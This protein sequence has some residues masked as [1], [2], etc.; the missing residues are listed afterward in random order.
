M[1]QNASSHVS[2]RYFIKA[3]SKVT[4]LN[5]II[6]E[7]T[8]T[9]WCLWYHQESSCTCWQSHGSN[10]KQLLQEAR[11]RQPLGLSLSTLK[12]VLNVGIN[13]FKCPALHERSHPAWKETVQFFQQSNRKVSTTGYYLKLCGFFDKSS[14]AD[15]AQ[16]LQMGCGSSLWHYRLRAH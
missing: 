7:H 13:A 2:K 6:E 1:C 15:K 3:K 4:F 16:R 10:R 11:M 8:S 9:F 14:L 12:N 5:H